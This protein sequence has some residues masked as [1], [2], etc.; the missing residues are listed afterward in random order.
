MEQQWSCCSEEERKAMEIPKTVMEIAFEKT[1]AI[2]DV[3]I[4]H[5]EVAMR[6]LQWKKLE[7]M[8]LCKLWL[9]MANWP[10]SRCSADPAGAR[11][12]QRT[13]TR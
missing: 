12:R 6:S 11:Q 2:R 4:R 8:E 1:K 3:A 13:K 10:R 7:R 9:G 5:V